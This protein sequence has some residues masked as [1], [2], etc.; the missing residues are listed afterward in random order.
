MNPAQPSRLSEAELA[1]AEA[2]EQYLASLEE[3]TIAPPQPLD[4]ALLQFAK[5]LKVAAR[6]Q[7][8]TTSAVE[9]ESLQSLLISQ[10][11]APQQQHRPWWL[12]LTPLPVLGFAVAGLW[13]WLKPQT[14]PPQQLADALVATDLAV[15]D[16]LD[17]DL[18]VMTADL[19]RSLREIDA[20]TSEDL[21]AL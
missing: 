19:D 6:P 3:G 16:Q 9:T 17:A 13:L 7:L 14:V 10:L 1:E 2:L 11:T 8:P 4:P 21:S 12:W 15:I 20:L 5:Q 18:A